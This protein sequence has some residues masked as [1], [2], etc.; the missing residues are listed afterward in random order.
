MN[1]LILAAGH[2]EFDARDG[3]YPLCLTEIEGVP[4]I[5]RIVQACAQLAPTRMVFALRKADVNRYHLDNVVGLVAPGA[6]VIQVEGDTPGAACTALLAA[7]YIDNDAELLVLGANELVD[8]DLRQLV[9]D[10]RARALDAGTVVFNSIHPRYSYVRVGAGGL[11]TEATE[12]NPISKHASAGLYWF[13]RGCELVAAIKNMIRKDAHVDGLFYICPA[14]N[15]MILAGARIG[16]APIEARQYHPLKSERQLH[17][18]GQ[19][20]RA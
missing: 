4:L 13:A 3:S 6:A 12:K 16:V 15:E 10:F 7:Q 20:E 11:V 2:P 5:D 17:N 14:F 18:F 19:G 1:I 9:Q 8:T